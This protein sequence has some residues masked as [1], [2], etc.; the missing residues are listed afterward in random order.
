[1]SI[2]KKAKKTYDSIEIP[3]ELEYVVNRTIHQNKSQKINELKIWFKGVTATIATT[4]TLFIIL[5]NTNE[6]FAKAGSARHR[7]N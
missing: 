7:R 1:M 4:F 5:L 2:L 6:S 3:Q